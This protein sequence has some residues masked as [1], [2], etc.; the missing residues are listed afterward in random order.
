MSMYPDTQHSHYFLMDVDEAIAAASVAKDFIEAWIE[1]FEEQ[2]KQ[3]RSERSQW[4]WWERFRNGVNHDG[5]WCDCW[6]RWEE[7]IPLIRRR[8]DLF[9]VSRFLLHSRSFDQTDRKV[10]ISPDLAGLLSP[11]LKGA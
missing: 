11:Y 7:N 10:S 6:K 5:S 1:R 2:R 3:E 8:E 4:T 9:L